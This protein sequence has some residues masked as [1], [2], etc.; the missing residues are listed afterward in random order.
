MTPTAPASPED[1]KRTLTDM[2][3]T[4]RERTGESALHCPLV[5]ANHGLWSLTT[6]PER[7]WPELAPAHRG[8][9][10]GSVT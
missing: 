3:V 4:C 6:A 1:R 8:E 10:R 9:N 2:A 7:A 5:S